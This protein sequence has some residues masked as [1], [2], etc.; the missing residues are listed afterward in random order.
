MIPL[1]KNLEKS[2]RIGVKGGVGVLVG[3]CGCHV[4]V[5]R[6]SGGG[7]GLVWGLVPKTYQGKGPEGIVLTKVIR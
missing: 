1:Q 5:V 4:H 7:G 2:E 6:K 3:R